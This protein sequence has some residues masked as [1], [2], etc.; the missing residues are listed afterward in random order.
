MRLIRG[1]AFPIWLRLHGPL[2][3]CSLDFCLCYYMYAQM[4]TMK[5]QCAQLGLSTVNSASEKAAPNLSSSKTELRQRD[6]PPPTYS[7]TVLTHYR[8]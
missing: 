5:A 6:P 8:Q 2:D 3:H 4:T 7:Y 1:A